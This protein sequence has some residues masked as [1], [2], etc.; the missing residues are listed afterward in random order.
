MGSALLTSKCSV[1]IT[2]S[3]ILGYFLL[4][5]DQAKSLLLPFLY[6]FNYLDLFI[7]EKRI[8]GRG[9]LC[10]SKKFSIY[11]MT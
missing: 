9:N 5:L 2:V 4:N 7:T 10:G 11:P 8:P 6:L 1:P 3:G